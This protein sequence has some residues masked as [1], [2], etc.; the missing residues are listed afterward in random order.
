[1]TLG[2][3]NDA[4]VLSAPSANGN[5]YTTVTDIA[6][7]DTINLAALTATARADAALGAK[8]ILADTAAFA[9]YL[10]AT[11]AADASAAALVNW[12]QYGGNTYIV[13]DDEAAASNVFDN[14]V[15]SVIKLTGLVDLTRS[16]TATDVLTIVA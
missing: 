11:T 1:M 16:T 7:G 4:L 14:G 5:S 6:V 12:F 8:V 15:D 13:V 3:G 9:D 10:A 2:A